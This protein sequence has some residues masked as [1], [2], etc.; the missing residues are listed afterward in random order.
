M[1]LTFS[2]AS[3]FPSI[4]ALEENSRAEGRGGE[5][6]GKSFEGWGIAGKRAEKEEN[7]KPRPHFG[8]IGPQK[9]HS[10]SEHFDQSRIR[11]LTKTT[12]VRWRTHT[13]AANVAESSNL[14][15]ITGFRVAVVAFVS[16]NLV[17]HAPLGRE[18]GI[19]FEIERRCP[20]QSPP[21]PSPCS[22]NAAPSP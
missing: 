1:E 17:L 12:S 5:A 2:S 11:V 18:V 3:W 6:K 8:Y 4:F 16:N 21:L 7:A 19:A 15:L 22:P 13:L 20:F 9:N 10:V 14:E